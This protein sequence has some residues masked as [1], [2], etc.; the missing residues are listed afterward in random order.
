MVAFICNACKKPLDMENE[1]NVHI[2]VSFGRNAIESKGRYGD[3]YNG[4]LCSGCYNKVRELLD[5]YYYGG[6]K[7]LT[8]GRD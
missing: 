4:D 2:L 1:G 8:E 7:W 6:N 3:S 5:V